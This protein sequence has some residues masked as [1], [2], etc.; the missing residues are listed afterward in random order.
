VR[1]R[2]W[3]VQRELFPGELREVLVQQL[4]QSGQL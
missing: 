1:C 3:L 4:D 2:G